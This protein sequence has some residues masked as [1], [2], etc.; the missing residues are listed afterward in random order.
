[1]DRQERGTGKLSAIQEIEQ[2]YQIKVVSIINLQS[3]I[4]YLKK[5]DSTELKQ[6]L[7]AVEAY[8]SEFGVQ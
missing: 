6:H 8:R 1:M 2:T 3:I 5:S 4:D 7:D